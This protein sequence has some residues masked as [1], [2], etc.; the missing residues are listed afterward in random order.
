ME[1]PESTIPTDIGEEVDLGVTAIGQG[2]VLA[3]PLEMASV[4]QTIGNGG[5]RQPRTE[6]EVQSRV[7]ARGGAD[8]PALDLRALRG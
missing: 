5:V 8:E 1:P 7:L 4:A 3:T 2:E 6:I